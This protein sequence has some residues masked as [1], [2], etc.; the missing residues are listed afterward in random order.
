MESAGSGAEGGGTLETSKCF[1]HLIPEWKNGEE[2]K[3]VQGEPTTRQEGALLLLLRITW[4][5]A[6]KDTPWGGTFVESKCCI[7]GQHIP[8]LQELCSRIVAGVE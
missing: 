6:F 8:L 4:R 5:V 1:S 3:S 2:S 7:S